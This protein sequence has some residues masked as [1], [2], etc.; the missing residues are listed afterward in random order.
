MGIFGTFSFHGTK[1]VTTGEGGMFVTNDN[2]LYERVMTLSNHGRA[3]SEMRQFWPSAIGYKY[4]MSNI[5]AAIG[6]AQMER[7]DELIAGK[8]RVFTYYRDRLADLP[9]SMNPE[10]AGTTNGYWMPTIVVDDHVPFERDELMAA[11]QAD[12]I[13]GRVFFW[14]L[15]RFPM[16]T[17]EDQ[18]T[19]NCVSERIHRRAV[20]LPTYH[21]LPDQAMDRVVQLVRDSTI[22]PASNRS[23]TR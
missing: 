2:V 14:P 20:N 1:T 17:C 4:K 11:F 7:I 19:A 16:F 13:D 23:V 10:P 12:N 15:S 21:D 22:R 9:L 8:R 6:C 18:R 5:Q 3:R